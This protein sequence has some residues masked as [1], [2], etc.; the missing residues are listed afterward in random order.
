MV[1][2]CETFTTEGLGKPDSVLP[3][4]TFP[5]APANAT[6]EVMTAINAVARR[7]KKTCSRWWM[8]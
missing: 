4:R 5:G 8:W 6:F 2:I 7:R 1:R 3:I